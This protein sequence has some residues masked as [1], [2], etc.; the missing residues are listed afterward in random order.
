MNKISKYFF[1]NIY[2][3]NPPNKR[4][5]FNE[6]LDNKA[7]EDEIIAILLCCNKRNMSI[8][9]QHSLIKKLCN[10]IQLEINEDSI[11]ILQNE[12]LLYFIQSNNKKHI[13]SL[14]SKLRASHIIYYEEEQ[15]I[16]N[17]IG[18][19]K[20]IVNEKNIKDI[21]NDIDF[22]ENN[23]YIELINTITNITKNI[24]SKDIQQKIKYIINNNKMFNI[25]ILG[26]SGAG[27]TTL[28]KALNKTDAIPSK[29]GITL[30]SS[31][32]TNFIASDAMLE[33][34]RY[35]NKSDLN[36]QNNIFIRSDIT[37]CN[38][39]IYE[40]PPI[41][42]PFTKIYSQN[43]INSANLI[44]Y[45]IDISKEISDIDINNIAFIFKETKNIIIICS[46][47]D[48]ISSDELK[49][50]K[51]SITKKIYFTLKRYKIKEVEIINKLNFIATAPNIAMMYIQDKGHLALSKGFRIQDSGI[52]KL[53]NY[54]KDHIFN[55]KEQLKT[56]HRELVSTL[57]TQLKIYIQMMQNNSIE[58]QFD[59][60]I[61]NE[62]EIELKRIKNKMYS[63]ITAMTKIIFESILQQNNRIN[64]QILLKIKVSDS[65]NDI[66][67]DTSKSFETATLKF[68]NNIK[69]SINLNKRQKDIMALHLNILKNEIKKIFIFKNPFLINAMA[70][71][72]NSNINKENFMYTRKCIF[73]CLDIENKITMVLNKS[74]QCLNSIEESLKTKHNKDNLK[75]AR[76]ILMSLIT[77]NKDKK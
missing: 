65:M 21:R 38:I 58:V 15:N 9:L 8:F 63:K 36:L 26:L 25:V 67:I 69:S 19:D 73:I 76:E 66:F 53:N 45:I 50:I 17:T 22:L 18:N 37:N 42:N 48:L 62:Y 31:K 11:K 49:I 28:I 59:H 1:L 71:L 27:K 47:F 12:A 32:N 44:L 75:Q 4:I 41:C 46:H 24:E 40:I 23:N 43:I 56:T 54:I 20:N 16:K 64:K 7:N 10:K 13:I 5:P 70:D 52:Y 61:I 74:K 57:S 30:I 68:L 2:N 60:Q 72:L 29:N 39:N 34:L 51:K 14:I 3:Q 55:N 33:I 35:Y 6:F 77:L